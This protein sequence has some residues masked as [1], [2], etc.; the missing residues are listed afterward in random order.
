MQT[1]MKK[2][3]YNMEILT[4]LTTVAGNISDAQQV[5]KIG[6]YPKS[7]DLPQKIVLSAY[8]VTPELKEKGIMPIPR[9]IYFSS[10]E[11][12]KDMIFNLTKAYF[13]FQDKRNSSVNSRE[14]FRKIQLQ[15]FLINLEKHQLDIW[16]K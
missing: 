1:K 2:T 13:F 10:H 16:R 11:Q 6:Y 8:M 14:L 3:I 15:D 12:L 4:P 7:I 5:Y 9:S